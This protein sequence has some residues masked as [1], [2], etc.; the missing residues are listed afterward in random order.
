M[1]F[2]S[3]LLTMSRFDKLDPNTENNHFQAWTPKPEAQAVSVEE[4]ELGARVRV[5]DFFLGRKR[6]L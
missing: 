5:P 2:P 4:F 6:I 1:I 3:Q